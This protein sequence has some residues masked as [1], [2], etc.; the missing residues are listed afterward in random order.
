[1]SKK[2]KP[3][4][5]IIVVLFILIILPFLV[6]HIDDRIDYFHSITV[7]DNLMYY[8]TALTIPASFLILLYTQRYEDEKHDKELEERFDQKVRDNEPHLTISMER[9]DNLY[10]LTIYGCGE[11]KYRNIYFYDRFVHLLA[12]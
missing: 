12:R 11:N 5:I 7:A 10:R 3:V 8:A 6:Q 2:I 9:N 4:W 1:M